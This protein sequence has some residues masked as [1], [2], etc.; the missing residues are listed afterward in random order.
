MTSNPV[1]TTSNSKHV[2]VHGKYV[3]EYQHDGV[4]K[5]LFVKSEDNDADIMTKNVGSELHN[6]MK[7]SL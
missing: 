5:I 6:N 7:R 4:V 1:T 3:A 2:D